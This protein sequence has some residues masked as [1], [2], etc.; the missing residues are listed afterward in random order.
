MEAPMT[1][2]IPDVL[3]VNGET[4][5]LFTNP[6]DGYLGSLGDGWPFATTSTANWRGYIASWEIRD[7]RLLLVGVRGWLATHPIHAKTPG[8]IPMGETIR[9]LPQE[10]AET[11]GRDDARAGG[12]ADEGPEVPLSHLFP[13]NA[14]PVHATWYSG[15]LRIPKGELVR[16]VHMGYESLHESEVLMTIQCGVVT[17]TEQ[18]DLRE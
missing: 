9:A 1:A 6:L 4:V 10:R 2:Q 18:V 7:G 3:L 13:G 5:P 17:G 8:E 16:Y 14:G 12:W 11:P 15:T